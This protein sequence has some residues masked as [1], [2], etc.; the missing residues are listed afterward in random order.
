MAPVVGDGPAA[1]ARRDP[2]SSACTARSSSRP[3][4]RVAARPSRMA[5]RTDVGDAGRS[6]RVERAQRHGRVRGL[7]ATQEPEPELAQVRVHDGHARAGP[8]P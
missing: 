8:C 5:A 7:V 3:G 2:R 4:Q 6:Q 1:V